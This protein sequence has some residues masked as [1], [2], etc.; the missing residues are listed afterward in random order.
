MKSGVGV[1]ESLEITSSV[2]QNVHFKD[3][4]LKARE[5]IGKGGQMSKIFAANTK[6]YPV[7]MSEMLSVGEETGKVTEMLSDVAHFYE[8]DVEQKTKDMSTVIEPFLIVVIGAAV[9]FFAIS[10]ISP[11][12]SLANVI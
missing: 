8:E 7:F 11:M 1:V 10:I 6:I 2:V 4:L 5:A 12:Y 9:A 3:V